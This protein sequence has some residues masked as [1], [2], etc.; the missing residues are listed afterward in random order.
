MRGYSR[1]SRYE[2]YRDGAFSNPR[3]VRVT[4]GAGWAYFRREA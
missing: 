1:I 3:L 4:R 2:F